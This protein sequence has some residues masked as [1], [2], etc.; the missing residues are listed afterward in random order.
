MQTKNKKDIFLV[1][2]FL[3]VIFTI[4]FVAG[5]P[6]I[7]SAT[8]EEVIGAQAD[9]SIVHRFGLYD[10]P[11]ISAY[12]ERVARRVL[13]QV[14][15]KEYDYHFRLLDDPMVNAFA[16]PG[17]YIYVTRGLLASVNSEAELAC[18]IGHEIGHVTGHHAMRQT[19][20]QIG[21]ILLALGGLAA[22]KEMRQNAGAW[23]TVST[24]LS[25]QIIAGYGREFEMESDQTGMIL[26]S[27]AGYDPG[28]M[29][30]FL[31]TLKLVDQLGGRTYHGFMA[32]HPDTVTRIIESE[33]KSE[34]LKGRSGKLKSYAQRY[35]EKMDGL[36]YGKVKHKSAPPPY[37][38]VVY[39]A[40]K[41]ENFRDIAKKTMGDPALGIEIAA[42]NGKD[43]SYIPKEGTKVKSLVKNRPKNMK[44]KLEE[45][46]K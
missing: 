14:T 39:T 16:L 32:S 27:E 37:K 41:N 43:V 15:D 3:T 46:G 2:I 18:V 45:A 17:G 19:K 36:R 34:I 24:T 22:S 23:L 40:G 7:G 10:D 25:S 29:A 6:A 21:S 38:I 30:R 11:K 5:F 33:G 28:G 35:I 31:S 44:L 1:R 42:L 26:A 4:L 8:D 9:R 13:D 12:V 20:K